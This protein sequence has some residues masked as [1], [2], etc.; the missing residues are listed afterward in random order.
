MKKMLCCGVIA[1]MF[2]GVIWEEVRLHHVIQRQSV[3]VE[4]LTAEVGDLQRAVADRDHNLSVARGLAMAPKGAKVKTNGT[5]NFWN[6]PGKS[7]FQLQNPSLQESPD[8]V[9]QNWEPFQFN[10]RTYYRIPLAS[11][12]PEPMGLTR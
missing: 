5:P 9:P 10:G 12:S 2:F 8:K 1:V 4:R 11:T 6:F 3:A 7:P